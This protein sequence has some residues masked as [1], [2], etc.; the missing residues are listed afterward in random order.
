MLDQGQ[1]PSAKRGGLAADVCSGLIFLKKKKEEKGNKTD[2]LNRKQTVTRYK[3]IQISVSTLNV[4]ELKTCI[5]SLKL[6]D[7]LKNKTQLH[8]A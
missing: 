1:S 4:K 2:E 3:Y 7:S 5:K 6:S 8:A